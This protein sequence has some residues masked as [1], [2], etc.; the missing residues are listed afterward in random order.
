MG[1]DA[2]GICPLHSTEKRHNDQEKRESFEKRE[3]NIAEP[4][5]NRLGG[6]FRSSR[7]TKHVPVNSF[8]CFHFIKV[9][10]VQVRGL[11]IAMERLWLV[12]LSKCSIFFFFFGGGGEKGG[13]VNSTIFLN[14]TNNCPLHYNSHPDNQPTQPIFILLLRTKTTI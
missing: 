8:S 2:G 13:G 9:A 10:G 6:A 5:E 14:V 3:S 4:L 12:L 1:G 7:S 11:E